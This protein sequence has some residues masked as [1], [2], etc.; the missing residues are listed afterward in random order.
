MSTTVVDCLTSP[1]LPYQPMGLPRVKL[2]IDGLALWGQGC[3]PIV[4]ALAWSNIGLPPTP[5]PA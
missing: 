4:G 1:I 5:T 2:S 3:Q